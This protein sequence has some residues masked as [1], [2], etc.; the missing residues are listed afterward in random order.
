MRENLGTQG[1][2]IAMTTAERLIQQGIQQ[3]RQEAANTAEKLIQQGRQEGLQRGLQNLRDVVRKLLHLKF[4]PLSE[5]H[6][7]R[8]RQA[9]A[10]Q[11]DLWAEKIL[12]ATSID[13]LF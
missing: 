3:G 5:E 11:L 8:V 2:Y 9:S 1:E 7:A 12:S 10:E 6:E 13:D 4:G